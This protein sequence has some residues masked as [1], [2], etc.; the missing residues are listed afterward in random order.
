MNAPPASVVRRRRDCRLC[1]GGALDL[2]LSLAP[3]PPAN[4]FVAQ[5]DLHARQDAFPLDLHL[6]RDCGH[7]QLLDVVDP[8][9]LFR[10]YVYV[11]GTSPVFLAHLRAYAEDAVARYGL[12]PGDLVVEVGS[13]DGSLLR[14]FRE[15]GMRVLGVDPA[16]EIA[17]AAN[18]AG[19]ETLEAFFEPELAARIREERGPA[20]LVAANNVFAH[21]DGLREMAEGVRSLLGPGGV[22]VFEVSYLLDVCEQLLFD[23]IYHEH[24][25]YHAVGPLRA[26]FPRCGM[27]LI[28]AR[29]VP[30][31]GGSLRGVAQPA[32]GPR[33]VSPGV[34]ELAAL[35]EA[36]GLR[37]PE[38]YRDFGARVGRRKE[39]L[40]E[41]LR[42]LRRQGKRIAGFGAP[43]KA[44]TLMYHFGLG[45]EVIDFVVDDSPWK[46]GLFT[47]GHHIPVLPAQAIYERRPDYVL[48]LAWNFAGPIMAKHKAFAEAG[49][50]FIV[51]LPDLRVI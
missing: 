12:K 17:R 46:Q 15:K 14:F 41:L 3:T 25:A 44:T 13:N 1:G 38:A 7:L 6:C 22:F 19:V 40:G 34:G 42:G 51:P 45:P 18:Q 11:S 37:R 28:D 27:E 31:H 35:E 8:D 23:T 48:V 47:P 49:G 33:P 4:A 29:R 50:R 24:L 43:A 21:A 2:V 26:F 36:A 30:T 10:H 20:A 39:E 16:Q 5:K 32:G 9:L